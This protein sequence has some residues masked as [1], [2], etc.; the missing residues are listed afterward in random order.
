MC[1]RSRCFIYYTHDLS[2]SSLW[3]SFLA[4][5][6]WL[7]KGEGRT[8]PPSLTNR[9]CLGG[10]MGSF[11]SLFL[12][13]KRISNRWHSFCNTL[14]AWIQTFNFS[15]LWCM[16]WLLASR[17]V[18]SREKGRPKFSNAW[19][20]K[21]IGGSLSINPLST[22]LREWLS[23]GYLVFSSSG[24]AV[25]NAGSLI[26][27]LIIVS[28]YTYNVL[29]IF[30]SQAMSLIIYGGKWKTRIYSLYK[31]CSYRLKIQQSQLIGWNTFN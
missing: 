7:T 5:F 16:F 26:D 13:T 14:R 4:I 15:K 6:N 30:Q 25:R 29:E 24:S 9:F 31:K 21:S 20:T 8:Y 27:I 3:T 28:Y 10:L 18:C 19:C 22:F 17:N 2:N 1:R 11:L 23:S 12:L